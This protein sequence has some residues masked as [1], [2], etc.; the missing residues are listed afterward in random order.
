MPREVVITTGNQG[1]RGRPGTAEGY[2]HTQG[3]ASMNWVIAHN[4]G[5]RPNVE[6]RTVGGVLF[7]GQVTH[8]TDNLINVAFAYAFAGTARLL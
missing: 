5:Y 4:L 8:V 2:I 3:S 6:L 1:P 7:D